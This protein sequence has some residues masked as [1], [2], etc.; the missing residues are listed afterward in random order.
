MQFGPGELAQAHAVDE[1]VRLDEVV[2]CARTYAVLALRR[3]GAPPQP[4]D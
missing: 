3:C 2:A 1:S 4:G